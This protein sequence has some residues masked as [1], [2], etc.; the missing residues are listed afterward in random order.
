MFLLCFFETGILLWKIYRPTLV[1]IH[2][3][4]LLKVID[5]SLVWCQGHIFKV[6]HTPDHQIPQRWRHGAVSS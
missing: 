5:L 6:K 3:F 1:Q 4:V 2:A